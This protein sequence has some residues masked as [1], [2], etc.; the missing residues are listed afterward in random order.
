MTSCPQRKRL[1]VLLALSCAISIAVTGNSAFGQESP[2]PADATN[3]LAA[4]NAY[5]YRLYPGDRLGR[6]LAA[7]LKHVEIDVCYDEKR[8]AVVV[9]HDNP[10]RGGEP[11]LGAYLEKIW[12]AWQSAPGAGYTLIIDFKSA[13]PAAAARV[14]EI[15]KLQAERLSRLKKQAGAEF[16]SGKVTVCLTGDTAAHRHYAEQIPAGDDYLAFGDVGGGPWHADAATYV[17]D[18]PPAFVRFVTLEKGVFRADPKDRQAAAF[19]PGRLQA[20]MEKANRLGY[21]VRVYTLNPPKLPAGDFNTQDW[22]AC[23]AGGLHMVSTDAYELARDWWR[24]RGE[25]K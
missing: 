22:E 18:D 15:L 12:Q 14:H 6:A 23:V 5:T 25:G 8:Q 24:Q 19:D 3:P 20:V 10:A 1:C 16:V 13:Q 9:T 2:H 11:E 21:R 17:P 4:H 7:G